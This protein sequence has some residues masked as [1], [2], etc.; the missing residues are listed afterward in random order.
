LWSTI[1]PA[2]W[3]GKAPGR[4]RHTVLAFFDALGQ[5]RS[6]QL[7]L[8][9]ADMAAWISGPIGERARQAARCV[10]PFHVVQL[11]TGALDDVRREVWNEARRQG[12]LASPASSKAHGSRSGRTPRTSLAASKPSWR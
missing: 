9:S 4:D 2:G 8:I 3:C 5:E 6:K 1:T 7:E 10:D 11:A 12:N